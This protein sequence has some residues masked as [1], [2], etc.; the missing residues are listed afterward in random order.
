[1]VAGKTITYSHSEPQRL[2]AVDAIPVRWRQVSP[3]PNRQAAN[4]GKNRTHTN[5]KSTMEKTQQS[6]CDT[7]V[8]PSY[9]KTHHIGLGLRFRALN[10]FFAPDNNDKKKT[11]ICCARCYSLLRMQKRAIHHP[12]FGGKQTT[13]RD[14]GCAVPCCSSSCPGL[15][16]YWPGLR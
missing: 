14:N 4:L 8:E 16:D 15:A 3:A 11:N 6:D 2:A 5:L 13:T 10:S 1:M 7:I 12:K 9:L